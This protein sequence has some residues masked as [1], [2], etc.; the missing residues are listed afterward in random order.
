MTCSNLNLPSAYTH[1][2]TDAQTE[3]Q[4]QIETERDSSMLVG[5]TTVLARDRDISPAYYDL[6]EK[7]L[8]VRRS[9]RGN[10]SRGGVLRQLRKT[11]PHSDT[12]L[13]G[14]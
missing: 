8:L 11:R 2:H 9:W 6:N 13:V 10:M 12:V 14:N 1:R 5:H 7:N 4:R 3:G